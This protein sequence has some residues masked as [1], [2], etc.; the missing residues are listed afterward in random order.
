M[1]VVCAC[2]CMYLHG[3]VFVIEKNVLFHLRQRNHLMI[4][5]IEV[6]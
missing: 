4:S 5:V 2:V 3:Y 1:C 6:V